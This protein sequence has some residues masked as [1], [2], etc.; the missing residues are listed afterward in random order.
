MN[1]L[2]YE[3]LAIGVIAQRIGECR[4]ANKYFNLRMVITQQT[5]GKMNLEEKYRDALLSVNNKILI[6]EFKAPVVKRTQDG[7][8]VLEYGNINLPK[9]KTI[10]DKKIGENNVVLALIHT[11]LPSKLHQCE[12]QQWL[13]PMVSHTGNNC[14]HPFR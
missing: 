3:N 6:I 11:L 7:D 12:I 5:I 10:A 1:K 9:L 14:L 13:L 2:I 8:I 4:F